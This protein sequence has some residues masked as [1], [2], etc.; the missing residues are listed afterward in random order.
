MIYFQAGKNGDVL[1]LLPILKN[2]PNGEMPTLIVSKEYSRILDRVDYVKPVIWPGDW[3]NLREGV[4]WAKQRFSNV[5]VPQIFGKDFPIAKLTPSFQLD[6][7]LRAGYLDKWDTLPLILKR[8][9]NAKEI[10][11]KHFKSTEKVIL[12]ADHSQSSPFTQKDEL[13][14]LLVDHFGSTHTIKRLSEIRCEHPLDLLALLDAA[15]C[16]VTIETMMLHLSAASPTP[17]IAMIGDS[18]TLWKGSAWSKR[19]LA[20]I[21][22]SDFNN[23][24]SDLVEAIK[25]GLNKSDYPKVEITPTPHKFAYNPSILLHDDKLWKTYR[26]HPDPKFWRTEIALADGSRTW[27]LD[28]PSFN[29]HS[30]E[31]MR[32]FSHRGKLHASLTVARSKD[33][34][35]RCAC[36][37]GEV[38]ISGDK[39]SLA[40]F[41]I[42]HYGRN[43]FSGME[44]NWSFFDYQNRLFFTYQNMPE[45]V[46]VELDKAKAIKEYKSPSPKCDYGI[47]RGGTQPFHYKGSLLRF[48]HV[49]QRN[50]R[51]DQYW[52]YHLSAAVFN[53]QPPFQITAFSSQPILSGTEQYFHGWK[54]YKPRCL[55]PY[56]AVADRDGW[57][58]ACGVNDSACSIVR[59]KE[60]DLHL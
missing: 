58:V 15:D 48:V 59:L 12:Y 28:L 60:T 26:Y 49:L 41:R 37:Y 16:L 20:H 10:V 7:W 29:D 13:Y 8:P 40:N 27:R 33:G 57:L 9:N 21:R 31:D 46:V 19:F 39:F 22:Y 23:R 38:T 2:E 24:K 30:L 56:G 50:E 6:Q 53:P 45:H 1:S 42:P 47:V 5:I 36:G 3:Q 55:L 25:R 54:Y 52:T 35:F 43:D 18:P 11:S 34:I 17:V 14:R 44:K 32:L 51:S 4:I